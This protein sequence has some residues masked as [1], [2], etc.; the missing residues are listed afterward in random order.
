MGF[1][2]HKGASRLEKGADN[3]EGFVAQKKRKVVLEAK[4]LQVD[5]TLVRQT[6]FFFKITCTDVFNKIQDGV[7]R[8]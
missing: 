1:L 7:L 3:W 2:K 4:L 5:E 8:K 6:S